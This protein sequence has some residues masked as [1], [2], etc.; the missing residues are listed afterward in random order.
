MERD[1]TN[2]QAL[3]YL[4]CL[5]TGVVAL[6]LRRNWFERKTHLR[7]EPSG[8]GLGGREA[9][10]LGSAALVVALLG[11]VKYYMFGPGASLLS[12]ANIFTGSFTELAAERARVRG[13]VEPGQGFWMAQFSANVLGVIAGYFGGISYRRSGLW[14]VGAAAA[15][16]LAFAI[17]LQQKAPIVW[18][19]VVYGGL[20]VVNLR[21]NGGKW[22][23]TR[24]VGI[25]TVCGV[26]FA[27]MA[28]LAFVKMEGKGVQGAFRAF[29]E[30]IVLVPAQSDSHYFYVFPDAMPFRG[31]IGTA[32]ID[33][34]GLAELKG[35][36]S[37]REVAR[38]AT[39]SE[40]SANASL[41]AIGWSGAGYWGV[42]SIC[43]LLWLFLCV[44]D[45]WIAKLGDD[46]RNVLAMV[47]IPGIAT[48]SSTSFVD[49]I[50]GGGL[51]MPLAV[52][53]TVRGW[54]LV[55]RR[56]IALTSVEYRSVRK[57]RWS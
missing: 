44:G 36:T 3:S 22:S 57:A 55:R 19:F 4:V 1:V 33:P 28:T 25:L 13:V 45:V 15:L 2:R 11:S 43:A 52:F 17:Q 41:I 21:G 29:I 34:P 40:F 53:G 18:T 10:L 26:L 32:H 9:V 12:E 54:N 30:R 24:I 35:T 47:A 27:S 42:G 39:G 51:V 31:P 6:Q 37:I 8:I 20:V 50:F 46:G 5:V 49:F 14:L 38:Q 23:G 16:A 56:R 7:E 48:L